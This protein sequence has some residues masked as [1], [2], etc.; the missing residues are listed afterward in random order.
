[1]RLRLKRVGR[2]KSPT[3]APVRAPSGTTV[4]SATRPVARSRAVDRLLDLSSMSSDGTGRSAT[5]GA[6][7]Q[8]PFG[9]CGIWRYRSDARHHGHAH[10]RHWRA[11]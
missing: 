6:T 4:R 5:L 9:P 10:R 2:P 3:E 8:A 1:M 7:T 11:P